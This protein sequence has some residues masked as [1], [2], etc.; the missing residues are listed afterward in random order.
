MKRIQNPLRLIAVVLIAMAAVSGYGLY[1]TM[2]NWAYVQE[3]RVNIDVDI[4]DD[5]QLRFIDG[6]HAV[7]T[8]SFRLSNVGSRLDVQIKELSYNAFAAGGAP[9]PQDKY[10]GFGARS[11]MDSPD[12]GI[13]PAGSTADLDASLLIENGTAY[14]DILRGSALAD[15]SYPIQV[16]GVIRYEIAEFPDIADKLYEFWVGGVVAS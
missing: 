14:M 8:V 2:I 11:F 1:Q 12:Q 9:M 6:G 4:L 15:G 13:V 7:L 16:Q 10:I 3:T 5:V